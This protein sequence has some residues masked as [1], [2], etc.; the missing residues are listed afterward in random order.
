[1]TEP[2]YERITVPLMFASPEYSVE[3]LREQATKDHSG[4]PI[5]DAAG[6]PIG[7]IDTVWFD[8]ESGALMA[9]GKLTAS[10]GL[11]PPTVPGVVSVPIGPVVVQN[12][13]E[14]I[15]RLERWSMPA[16]RH[17]IGIVRAVQEFGD[18]PA[19]LGSVLGELVADAD[20][21]LSDGKPWDYP[22]RWAAN[23]CPERVDWEGTQC[24]GVGGHAGPKP[25]CVGAPPPKPSKTS[26]EWVRA[27]GPGGAPHVG[28]VGRGRWVHEDAPGPIKM[29]ALYLQYAP[30]STY[31]GT[32]LSEADARSEWCNL[33]PAERAGWVAAYRARHHERSA[34]EA[35]ALALAEWL[36]WT[37]LPPLLRWEGAS[38]EL[39]DT[40]CNIVKALM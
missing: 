26:D 27:M 2:K 13:V 39:Q 23:G 17:L 19:A 38:L 35:N 29:H 22:C 28:E 3:L 8:E 31:R 33:H 16:S 21:W 37:E 1:M 24:F 15:E 18:D 12:T 11:V 20:A 36:G 7:V 25:G 40:W 30:C 14:E 9:S 5:V 34:M 4:K 32:I 6:K 10:P